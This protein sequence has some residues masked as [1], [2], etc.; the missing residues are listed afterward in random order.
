MSTYSTN[1]RLELITS[2]TQAGNWGNTT[3]TN[4]GTL[5]EQAITGNGAIT[6]GAGASYTLT[7]YSGTSDESRNASLTLSTASQNFTL[8]LP[9]VP[10]LYIIYNNSGYT[11]TIYN[12]GDRDWETT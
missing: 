8:F 1:L 2:G 4:L 7:A 6:I 5:V 11:A 12:R 3:N 10:K 9:A